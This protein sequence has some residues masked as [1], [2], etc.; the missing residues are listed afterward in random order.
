MIV[1]AFDVQVAVQPRGSMKQ[2]LSGAWTWSLYLWLVTT[3]KW[4]R[5]WY[6]WMLGAVVAVLLVL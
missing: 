5:C 6:D 3:E 2:D 4:R 1:W